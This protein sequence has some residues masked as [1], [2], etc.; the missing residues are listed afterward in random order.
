MSNII[1]FSV[2]LGVEKA[3]GSPRAPTYAK[4]NKGNQPKPANDVSG[5]EKAPALKPP[6]SGYEE[7]T[8]SPIP[9]LTDSYDKEPPA[10][11]PR[12][13]SYARTSTPATGYE[14]ADLKT[15]H[16][17]STGYEEATVPGDKDNFKT[18]H[19]DSSGYEEA[20]L[21]GDKDNFKTPHGGY[22]TGYEDNFVTPATGLTN[23][24]SGYEDNFVTPKGYEE[25]F[26]T[27]QA[28]GTKDSMKY[29]HLK[30]KIDLDDTN[31]SD[32]NQG[33]KEVTGYGQIKS[34]LVDA[35]EYQH[36]S[37]DK[38]PSSVEPGY[39]HLKK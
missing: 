17:D 2:S 36:L 12:P 29:D 6:G 18:P 35:E 11:P 10:T 5:Y 39:G 37:H 8:L 30:R 23:T 15:P 21:P 28:R 25:N 3:P 22:S 31:N 26:V 38:E 13:R 16:R 4:P 32:S 34:E 27:P 33:A 20:T 7:A 1:D 24:S 9:R 19:G 14:E